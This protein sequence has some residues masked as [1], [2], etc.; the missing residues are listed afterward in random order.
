MKKGIFILLIV[1][2][3]LIGI[4]KIGHQ[5][6]ATWD[7]QQRLYAG[8]LENIAKQQAS[9]DELQARID[10]TE[11]K[12]VLSDHD[13][14]LIAH[15]G[16]VRDGQ[17]KLLHGLQAQSQQFFLPLYR[18]WFGNGF[19]L[20]IF[21]LTVAMALLGKPGRLSKEEQD[22]LQRPLHEIPDLYVDPGA[23][24][25]QLAPPGSASNFITARL[26]P[27]N[28]D[29]LA[30]VRSRSLTAMG[31]AF[32]LAPQGG[33]LFDLKTL[34]DTLLNTD[35]PFTE[36]PWNTLSNS[37][38]VSI[39]FALVGLYLLF[40]T[41]H[42]VRIDRRKQ[43]INLGDRTLPFRDVASLQLNQILTTGER[44]YHNS[45]IQLNLNNGECL[46]LLNHAGDDAMYVD[47]IRLARFMGKPV[48]LNR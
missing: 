47:L 14:W 20:V 45:Q 44:T 8:L 13:R 36:L 18:S 10:A 29:Q 21:A 37:L 28:A 22:W 41:G 5:L 33:L 34:V 2:F 3:L 38:M 6:K 46:S 11:S 27:R 31:L 43:V 12:V 30:I 9:V 25:H 26:K 16:K 32:L 42:G 24:R 48:A 35:T 39:P 15:L 1:S 23:H 17:A 7:T 40:H 19:M 4:S